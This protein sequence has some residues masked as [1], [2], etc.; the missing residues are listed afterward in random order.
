MLK[1]T[2][3]I[4][5]TLLFIRFAFAWVVTETIHVYDMRG[6]P[7]E[8]L[9]VWVE[10]QR[11]SCDVLNETISAIT[12]ENGTVMLRISNEAPFHCVV[13][14]YTIRLNFQNENYTQRKF[15][16]GRT[17]STT[18]FILPINM[19]RVTV[20]AINRGKIIPHTTISVIYPLT[21]TKK[22][23]GEGYVVFILYPSIPY[24]FS[25][26]LGERKFE[27]TVYINGDT[28]VWIEIEN[29]HTI[30]VFDDYNKPISGAHVELSDGTTLNG[31]TDEN[32]SIFFSNVPWGK[33]TLKMKYGSLE[34]NQ[35]INTTN[36]TET[37]IVIDTHP[38]LISSINVTYNETAVIF[39]S[40]ITDTM[41]ASE[42]LSAWLYYSTSGSIFNSKKMEF[43]GIRFIATVPYAARIHYFIV[44]KDEFGNTANTTPKEFV[45]VK[46][47]QTKTTKEKRDGW[48]IS[49]LIPQFL[50]LIVII[51]LAILIF[52]Y[53]LKFK[54]SVKS[55]EDSIKQELEKLA[56][57]LSKSE[58]EEERTVLKLKLLRL[59][60]KMVE[61]DGKLSDK[62][63]EQILSE[64]DAEMFRLL[65]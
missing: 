53:Y 51:F 55:E 60:K 13:N 54:T 20:A 31:I 58:S 24:T 10:Y 5:S 16:S 9:V 48:G 34:I 19:S 47:S 40:I 14:N 56:A 8:N 12:N 39:A 6:N 29:N 36:S 49:P 30:T 42:N 21:K 64:I 41:C 28:L 62:E 23:S 46:Y 50:L 63:K 32:G 3:F 17:I 35:T 61:K 2:F 1:R 15:Y 37:R 57:E 33:L 59:R 27:K 22:A 7:I 18:N 52:T 25:V 38:P 45:I 43:D 4:I 44:A 11:N 65:H 26:K